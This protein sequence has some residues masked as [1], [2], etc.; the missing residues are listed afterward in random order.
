[1]GIK[2]GQCTC[3]LL[4]CVSGKRSKTVNEQLRT[5]PSLCNWCQRKWFVK[6]EGLTDLTRHLGEKIRESEGLGR[7]AG[8]AEPVGPTDQP[9]VRTAW[10]EGET[11]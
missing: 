10:K 9:Q 2:R 1:M 6:R 3:A 5:A 7:A 11:S 8:R 4:P